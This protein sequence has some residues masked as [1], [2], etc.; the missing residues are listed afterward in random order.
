V[1]KPRIHKLVVIDGHVYGSQGGDG[2][3]LWVA[4]GR[5]ASQERFT[6]DAVR[7]TCKQCQKDMEA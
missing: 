3:E 4:C 2:T 1:S 6:T 5:F 7:V